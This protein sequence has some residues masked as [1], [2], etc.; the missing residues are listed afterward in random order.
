MTDYAILDPEQPVADSVREQLQ[1]A[2]RYAQSWHIVHRP[3]TASRFQIR[4]R[5]AIHAL[6]DLEGELALVHSPGES[7]DPSRV[8][9]HAAVY[10][11]HANTWLMRSAISGVSDNPKGITELP[12][13]L[14]PQKVEEPRAAAATESF[15]EAVKG[16]FTAGAF[17]SF[18]DELQVHEALTAAEL[19]SFPAFLKFVLLEMVVARPS[20]F[21]ALRARPRPGEFPFASRASARLAK[22]NGRN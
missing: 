10:D 12:R 22:S 7:E 5:A 19:W 15:L 9:F 11:L 13:V 17:R 16:E 6:K 18:V 8:E 14:S 3:T 4:V 2:A 20:H 21:C 1:S